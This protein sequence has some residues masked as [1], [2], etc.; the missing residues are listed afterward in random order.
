MDQEQNTTTTGVS[1]WKRW[2]SG[3]RV[4]VLLA[5]VLVLCSLYLYTWGIGSY[6]LW[7][8]W[9]PKY[10]QALREMVERGDFI[11][12]YYDDDVRWTKPILIYWAMYV[13]ILIGGN[14]EFTVRLPSAVAAIL[15]VL[16]VFLFLRNLRGRQTA[17]AAA[18]I[19]GT[20]PQY[21]YMARQAMPDMLLTLF[22]CAAMVFFAAAR[23]GRHHNKRYF[24]LFYVSV[25]LA[26]LTKGPVACVIVLSSIVMFWMISFDPKR[27]L[28]PR[29]VLADV[30]NLFRD[31]HVALGL[32]IFLAISC[33]WYVAMLIKHGQSFIDTFV[34]YENIARFR[35]PIRDHHGLFTYYI[36]TFFHGMYPWGCMLP[37]GLIFLF[38]GRMESEEQKQRWYF[39]SWF[40]AIFLIFTIA[41]TK[42]QHYFLTITP[43]AA[44]LIA[45][46]W[47]QYFKTDA[48][49][50]V[51][52]VFL[53]S[54]AFFLLPI[55]D[56][57][58]EGNRYIFDN[59]TN[60]RTID[61]AD[62][63][64]FLKSVF[65]AWAIVMVLSVFW[66]RS[67]VVLALAVLV[68][69]VNGAYFCHYIL[70]KHTTHRTV[71]HYVEYCTKNKEPDSL[72]V[73]YGKIR[74]SM[75]YYAGR[76]NYTHF[77]RGQEQ[78]LTDW[79]KGERQVFI[80]AER[81]LARR[82]L[83]RLQ[84]RTESEWYTVLGKHV[85]Y[86]LIANHPPG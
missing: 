39:L 28:V 29:T 6:A 33:P 21:F 66:R 15:G 62:V 55:R 58:L 27:L 31:Y 57:L 78:K 56:F 23:F 1:L 37:A 70:P 74:P 54:I 4:D 41:G 64:V 47:E 75:N 69:Y 65:I 43:V 73:F 13:P 86:D 17:I 60:K 59:F 51:P 20:M 9:E 50:W 77:P 3:R 45:L 32:L 5:A 52:I 24:I 49:P 18:C 80:I 81:R 85:R 76:E 16:L 68:A 84:V 82:L 11:T 34:N 36:Q 22:L 83:R 7:D 67:R 2:S 26:F 72:L 63:D 44:I 79:V 42:Q 25:S 71:K 35:E 53:I 46:I 38:H 30:R 19:L 48:P 8:P 61:S 12:P 10:G 14:N 40:I